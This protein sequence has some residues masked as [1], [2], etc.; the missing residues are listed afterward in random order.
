MPSKPKP[1]LALAAPAKA[2]AGVEQVVKAVHELGLANGPDVLAHLRK[3]G[4]KLSR[5]SV[6]R[7]LEAAAKQG[8]LSLVEL[9]PR[10]RYFHRAAETAV[11]AAGGTRP[12]PV[13]ISEDIAHALE[14]LRGTKGR[15]VFVLLH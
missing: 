5:A 7:H 1:R 8:K 13:A 2:P 3:G 11:F 10:A 15:A 14:K 4:S 6:F 9:G 12:K